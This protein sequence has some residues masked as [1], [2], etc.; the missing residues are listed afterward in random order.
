MNVSFSYRCL[1]NVFLKQSS[2]KYR[3]RLHRFFCTQNVCSNNSP[4]TPK[5]SEP[6]LDRRSKFTHRLRDGPNLRDFFKDDHLA[7]QEHLPEEE[8]IPY[9]R[10][11]KQTD[12]RR[13]VYLD[14]YGCQMNV[15][16][17]EIVLS[18]LKDNNFEPTKDIIEA[19]VILVL[20]CAIRD[21][22]EEKIWGR[23]DFL[24]GIKRARK[25]DRPSLKIGLLG[26]MAERL[27]NKVLERT[28]MVDLVAGPDSYRDLPRLLTLT[29]NN[30]KSVNVLLS[31]DET[32]AD[33]TPV[34]YFTIVL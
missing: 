27:K 19:D 7:N 11:S 2:Y 1:T 5:E 13:K 20:T 28:N 8:V 31:L 25:K 30:Q 17:A 26:C 18:I 23:L 15:N 21:S 34:L 16:D 6:E 12:V 24:K 29:D 9:L 14:V 22:A 32:Y 3:F 10:F 33:I 4:I